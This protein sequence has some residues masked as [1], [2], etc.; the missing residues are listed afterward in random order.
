MADTDSLASLSA[1]HG[2]RRGAYSSQRG[3]IAALSLHAQGKTNTGPA[4]QAFL[5]KFERE[6]DPDGVLPPAERARRAAAARK[7]H[8]VRAAYA[9]AKARARR[10]KS[11]HR[12]NGRGDGTTPP[13]VRSDGDSTI[14]T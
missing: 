14:S 1:T 11:P 2:G 7:L 5:S 9:S 6:V 8:F 10:K 3:R 4:R 13:E 12:A